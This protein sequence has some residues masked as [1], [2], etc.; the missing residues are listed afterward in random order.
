M[1]EVE[2]PQTARVQALLVSLASWSFLLF[3]LGVPF[4]VHGDFAKSYGIGG[5]ALT[6]LLWAAAVAVS[7]V[8]KCPSCG[9]A[10]LIGRGTLRAGPDWPNLRK[11]FLPLEALAGRPMTIWCPHCNQPARMDLARARPK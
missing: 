5:L 7:T 8:V 4:A 11:Q 1:R 2:N 3:L 6:G 9:Q 10:I